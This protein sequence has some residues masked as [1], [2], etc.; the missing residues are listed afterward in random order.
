VFTLGASFLAGILPNTVLRWTKES[1]EQLRTSV[2]D[3][4]KSKFSRER[5]EAANDRDELSERSPLSQLDDVD[6]YDRTRLEEEGI[7]SIQALARHDLVDLILSSRIPV[8]RLIDWV[9]QAV[10]HQ[11]VPGEV[12]KLRRLGIRTA[13]DYLQ[14]CGSPKALYQLTAALR[15]KSAIRIELLRTVLEGDEWMRY[16]CN[17]RKHDGS[18]A[19]DMIVYDATGRR[20]MDQKPI[21]QAQL[22]GLVPNGHR[23]HEQAGVAIR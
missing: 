8:P 11:H 13:T 2:Q 20:R 9:D 3:V 14:V 19:M 1:V 21:Q 4:A 10:L 16:L 6:I 22:N 5:V 7:T 12:A 18:S 23:P 15:G 17:W